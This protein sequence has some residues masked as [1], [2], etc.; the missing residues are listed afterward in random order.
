MSSPSVFKRDLDHALTAAA[1]VAFV[2]GASRVLILPPTRLP[3]VHAKAEKLVRE[4]DEQAISLF[5]V[6]PSKDPEWYPRLADAFQASTAKVRIVIFDDLD[7][8]A[9]M[10]GIGHK[11]DPRYDDEVFY[12][13]FAEWLDHELRN[14]LRRG[15]IV[16]PSDAGERLALRIQDNYSELPI[17]ITP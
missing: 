12:I 5:T 6:T 8:E 10:A 17:L 1:S 7:R 16:L 9:I 15:V 11:I 4:D 3:E 13:L 14:H 2:R